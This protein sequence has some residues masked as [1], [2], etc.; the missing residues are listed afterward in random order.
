M[1]PGMDLGPVIPTATS[2]VM[3][4]PSSLPGNV[5]LTGTLTPFTDP[6]SVTRT[7]RWKLDTR[8]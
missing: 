8:A 4:S 1:P 2:S 6:Q 3:F 5:T 7:R